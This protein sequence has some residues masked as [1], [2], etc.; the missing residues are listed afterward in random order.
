MEGDCG[1]CGGSSR[2]EFIAAVGAAALAMSASVPAGAD[3]DIDCDK[4]HRAC[5]RGCDELS[6]V[7]S[8][9]C[10]A[11][12]EA[13]FWYCLSAAQARRITEAITEATRWIATHP[14]L[15]AGAVLALGGFTLLVIA[16]GGGALVA[17][18]A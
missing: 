15:A 10:K 12:C 17:V 8:L 2:R 6:F 13:Q 9:A 5:Q 18:L 1:G 14:G 11:R 7:R 16:T 4:Q 3:A